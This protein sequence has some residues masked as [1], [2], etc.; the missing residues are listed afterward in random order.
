MNI[1]Q[2][3]ANDTDLNPGDSLFSFVIARVKDLKSIPQSLLEQWTIEEDSRESQAIMNGG[4]YYRPAII[5]ELY[6]KIEKARVQLLANEGHLA[7]Q[8]VDLQQ[9]SEVAFDLAAAKLTLV[10]LLDHP[11]LA[12]HQPPENLMSKQDLGD[13]KYLLSE[14]QKTFDNLM[15]D[16]RRVKEEKNAILN[17]RFWK[18]GQPIRKVVAILRR[19]NI[20]I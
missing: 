5:G 11:Y 6:E 18:Y 2:E 15:V 13:F 16:Y 4:L 20:K 8:A 14:F 7:H 17:S 10:T 1:L 12:A 3:D 9:S 19:I